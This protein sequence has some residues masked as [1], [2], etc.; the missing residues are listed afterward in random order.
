LRIGRGQIEAA[1]LGASGIEVFV[2]R[3]GTG[4]SERLQVDRVINCTGPALDLRTVDE[5]LLGSLFA[6]GDARPG[7][8]GF[9]LD[10]DSRGALIGSDGRSSPQLFALGPVLKGRLWETT[11]I[12]EIRA[13][14]LELADQ[15][16][17]S[18][19]RTSAELARAS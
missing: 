8:L 16:A 9:G 10:H 12:P 5:A 6:S 19:T 2:R 17:A 7:P 18:L 4:A 3:D 11:A 14:A 13:Q 1:R 15:L